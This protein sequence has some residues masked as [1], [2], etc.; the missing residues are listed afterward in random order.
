MKMKKVNI[1]E[2]TLR[3]LHFELGTTH[4]MAERLKVSNVTVIRYMR[5]YHIPRTTKLHLYLNNSGVGRLCELYVADFPYFRKYFTDFGEIDDKNKFDG[6]WYENKVNIKSTHSKGR[7]S[8]R[9]KKKR[10]DVLYYICCV[11]DDD[12][13]PLIPIAIYVIPA[14]VYPRTTITISLS[15]NSKYES[16]RLKPRID[17]DVEEAERYNKEFKEK[18]SYPV[19]R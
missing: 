14:R 12:I 1:D 4:K 17:F 3:K 19:N 15:P 5:T 9:V 7:K 18:Y 8:F 11:Y 10:H 13:D 6:L 2:Q 16:F